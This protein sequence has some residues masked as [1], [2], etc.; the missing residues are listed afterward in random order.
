MEEE[1]GGWRCGGG[2]QSVLRD[3]G[4]EPGNCDGRPTHGNQAFQ[5]AC[6]TPVGPCV[7]GEEEAEDDRV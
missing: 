6:F 3:E 4:E 5:A 7:A 2:R 1:E